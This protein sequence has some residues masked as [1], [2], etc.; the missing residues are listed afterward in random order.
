MMAIALRMGR[1]DRG[2]PMRVTDNVDHNLG[3]KTYLNGA[4]VSEIVLDTGTSTTDTIDYVAT[5][6]TGNTA[7][8]TRTVLVEPIK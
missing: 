8:S 6:T 1:Y 4:L 2:K 3:I 7:M 5:D